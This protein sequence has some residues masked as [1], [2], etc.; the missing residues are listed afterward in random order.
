MNF[1]KN[2]KLQAPKYK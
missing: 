2:N 1:L